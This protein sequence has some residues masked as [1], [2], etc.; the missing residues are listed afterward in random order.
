MRRGPLFL[1]A[2]L[3]AV[4][5]SCMCSNKLSGSVEVNGEK[6]SFSSCRN[7]AVHGYRGVELT[8]SNG[9]RLRIGVLPTGAAGVIIMP[10]GQTVGTELGTACGSLN[11]SDQNSTVNDVKNVEG[12]AV[13]DCE[14][15]GFKVK[16]EVSFEN[17]H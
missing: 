9:T 17:C 4:F 5:P 16:G 11:I 15:N 7:G 14:G 12:K 3:I 13:L 2:F 6:L 8:A 10:K 1:I